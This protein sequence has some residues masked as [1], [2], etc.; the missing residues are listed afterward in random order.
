MHHR[1]TRAVVTILVGTVALSIA[2]AARSQY[3]ANFQTNIIS[4]VTSNWSGSYY[5]GNA[6]S[7]D[8]L[9][10]QSNGVLTDGGAYLGYSSTSS[11]NSVIVTDTGSIWSN[12]PLFLYVGY[13]GFGNSLVVSNGAQVL[14]GG[15]GYVGGGSIQ[16]ISSNSVVVTGGNSVWSNGQSLAVG[17]PGAAN[18]LVVS[19]GGLVINNNAYVGS[20][21]ATSSNNTVVVSDT[22]S[23]WTNYGDLY[24]GD[25]GVSNSVIVSNGAKAFNGYGYVGNEIGA[26]SNSLQVSGVGSVWTNRN[27]LH[28]GYSGARNSLAVLDSGAVFC[29]IGYIGN[30]ATAAS[31]SVLVAGT[32]SV[33]RIVNGLYVGNSAA[34]NSLV[35]SNQ[36]RV[37]NGYTDTYVGYNSSSSNNSVLV[38]DTGSMWSNSHSLYIGYTGAANSLI[39][40]NGGRVLCNDGTVGASLSSTGN[41][42]WVTSSG[43]VWSNNA[44]LT[45]GY[46]GVGNSLIISN[47]GQVLDVGATLGYGYGSG[48]NNTVFVTGTGSVWRSD[49]SLRISVGGWSNTVV[50]DNGGKIVDAYGYI[51][52]GGGRRNSVL[53]TGP[54]S[55][56]SNSL[57]LAICQFG[58][59]TSLVISNGAEVV[60]R[61]AYIGYPITVSNTVRVSSGGVWRN[62]SLTVG[63]GGSLN[64]LL[65]AGGTVLATNLTIGVAPGSCND[66]VQL[67]SGTVYVTNATGDAVFEVR[68]GSL[69][70]NGGTLQVDTLV[71]TNA[72]GLFVPNGGALLYNQLVLD[73]NLSALG[74]GI[75]NGWKQQYGFDP[76]DPTVAS[77]DTDGDGMSNLQEFL[78]GTDP[79]DSASAFRIT[80]V[81]GT[82]SD[83]LVSWMTGIGKTNALQVT[84]GP[85]GGGYTT[86]D[87]TDI[88]IVT[89]TVGSTTNY[90]DT[91][92]ATNA[93][94]RYYRVRLVP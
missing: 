27:D 88:F 38:S 9:L 25:R 20:Y 66:L 83:V 22:G 3:T 39:I 24:A 79:T 55:A 17:Y 64:T 37:L 36:G 48:S 59:E 72:C 91:G 19:H 7:A 77:A 40:S 18:R 41:R 51:A 74:D 89:N 42:V 93:P 53:V 87:F 33:W 58:S 82:G 21:A 52:T 12:G 5:V 11:N 23:V 78:A 47:G 67:D 26:S 84:A 76:L 80:S 61:D 56:W 50:V 1:A 28:I 2:P 70:L 75:P 69:I 30:N 62:E 8:V 13:N 35:I 63:N 31:N 85:P 43:S 54:G 4:S 71:M 73:P 65:V 81:I 86:N 90:L 46:A 45:F 32:G 94:A 57:D 92:G 29:S 10:I 49:I 16:R 60:N 68:Y 14:N 44:G 34:G 6:F 15:Y